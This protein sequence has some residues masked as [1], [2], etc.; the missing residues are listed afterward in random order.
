MVADLPYSLT[1]Q[2][3]GLIHPYLILSSTGALCKKLYIPLQGSRAFFSLRSPNKQK[4]TS[5]LILHFTSPC[6]SPLHLF[7]IS[8]Y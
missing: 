2:G 6:K 5:K 7:Y 4:G 3:H 8:L 1:K